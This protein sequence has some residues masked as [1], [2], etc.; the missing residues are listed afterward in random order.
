MSSSDSEVFKTG[1][2]SPNLSGSELVHSIRER[3]REAAE[4]EKQKADLERDERIAQRNLEQA[5]AEAEVAK[6]KALV[7]AEVLKER[8][9]L[10]V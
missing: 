3:Q 4:L 1:G 9:R 2:L 5:K 10:E 6:Q 8:A 7:D